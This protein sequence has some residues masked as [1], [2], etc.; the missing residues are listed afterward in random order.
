MALPIPLPLR[1][2]RSVPLLLPPALVEEVLVGAVHTEMGD[3]ASPAP[4]PLLLPWLLLLPWPLL[5]PRPMVVELSGDA[6][7]VPTTE[8]PTPAAR[9]HWVPSV[10]GTAARS[11]G[12]GT[13][14]QG[15]QALGEGEGEGVGAP[16]RGATH[17]GRLSTTQEAA[18]PLGGGGGRGQ[19]GG[20]GS[21][22]GVGVVA[23]CNG[24]GSAT[25]PCVMGHNDGSPGACPTPHSTHTQT[26]TKHTIG[27]TTQHRVGGGCVS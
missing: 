1:L 16:H 19:A 9:W 7:G 24:S 27:V 18:G 15:G 2:L 26:G 21:S 3:V 22:A 13:Q 11:P 23:S 25:R 14:V 17:R 5:P 20:G 4:L 6:R 12:H 8:A 10:E